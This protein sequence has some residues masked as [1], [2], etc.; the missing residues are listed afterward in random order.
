MTVS[1]CAQYPFHFD[2]DQDQ[3]FKHFLKI[4]WF[5]NM[6][7]F[8]ILFFRFLCWN[9]VNHLEVWTFLLIY[10]PDPDPRSQ[11][12]LKQ[13]FLSWF[14]HRL[15]CTQNNQ[16]YLGKVIIDKTYIFIDKWLT[17]IEEWSLIIDDWLSFKHD[18]WLFGH[19]PCL[20]RCDSINV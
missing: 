16:Q 1:Y 12:D 7:S 11:M 19:D 9:V 3:G 10:Y 13:C 4:Y 17:I 18:W 6:K 14:W 5:F 8:Y 20:L 2:A 15:W